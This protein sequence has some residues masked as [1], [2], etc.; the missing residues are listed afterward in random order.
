MLGLFFFFGLFFAY[1]KRD[2]HNMRQDGETGM[3]GIDISVLCASQRNFA[4]EAVGGE[5][6]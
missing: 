6:C 5:L 4:A 3:H 1:H 2:T